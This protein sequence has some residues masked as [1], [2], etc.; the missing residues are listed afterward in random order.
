VT[1]RQYRQRSR[2]WSPT[3]AGGGPSPWIIGL[4]QSSIVLAPCSSSRR[5]NPSSDTPRVTIKKISFSLGLPRR[6]T[7]TS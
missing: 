6:S 4:N 2:A 1:A 3:A 5:D 7:A